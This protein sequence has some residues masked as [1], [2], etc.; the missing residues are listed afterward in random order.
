MDP[1]E[2]QRAVQVHGQ[3]PGHVPGGPLAGDVGG[4]D[5]RRVRVARRHSLSSKLPLG[6]PRHGSLDFC[7]LLKID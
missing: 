6:N 5:C 2:R 3:G 1:E 4:R 7:F